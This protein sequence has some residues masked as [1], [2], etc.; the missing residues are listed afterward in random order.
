MAS[1]YNPGILYILRRYQHTSPVR[2]INMH[3]PNGRQGVASFFVCLVLVLTIYVCLTTDYVE[4]IKY[5]TGIIYDRQSLNQSK[6]IIEEGNGTWPTKSDIMYKLRSLNQSKGII[7]EGN[8]TWPTKSD[9][10]YKLRSLNQSKGIAGKVNGTRPTKHHNERL[11]KTVSSKLYMNVGF[12]GRLGNVM[13]QYAMLYATVRNHTL[14]DYCIETEKQIV[15]AFKVFKDSLTLPKCQSPI[16]NSTVIGENVDADVM[17]KRL[18]SLPRT[19]ITF[20]GYYQSHRYFSHVKKELRREFSLPESTRKNVT[21]YFHSIAP[22]EWANGS[23]VRVGVHVRRTDMIAKPMIR[24]GFVPCT[25]EYYNHSMRYFTDRYP[26]VQ[27]IVTS[28]DMKWT[29]QHVTG[30]HVIYSSHDYIMDFGILV[31][32][33]HII[34]GTGTFSW[35]AGWLCNGTTIYYG[36]QP[37]KGKLFA[38]IMANN[39]WWPPDDEYNK[40]IPMI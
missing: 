40:W 22:P 28:D 18:K 34:I 19:N 38:T 14:W 20:S 12:A 9:I 31:M 33:D 21:S 37:P 13:F 2:K 15:L 24:L 27:F 8:G 23:Y 11:N 17:I 36:V 7:E 30:A 25:A 29:K 1:M 16:R 26:R 39:R 35:W 5:I 6:G 3:A 10:M 4:H 32:S